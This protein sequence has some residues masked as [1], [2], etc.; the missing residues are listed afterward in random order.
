[1]INA[2]S[3]GDGSGSNSND[4]GMMQYSD[5]DIYDEIIDVIYRIIEKSE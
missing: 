1:V 2:G 5:L 3:H 4:S